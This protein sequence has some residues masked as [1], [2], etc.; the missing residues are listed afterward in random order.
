MCKQTITSLLYSATTGDVTA[1]R[2]MHGQG[3]DMGARDY[4]GRTALHLA[5]A[6]GHLD[7]VKFLIISCGMS[8]LVQDR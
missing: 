5:A 1:L 2:R 8:P 7:C 4:D 3:M 6:E